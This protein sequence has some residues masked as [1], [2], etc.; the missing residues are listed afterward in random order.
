MQFVNKHLYIWLSAIHSHNNISLPS[1]C[2]WCTC[3][4]HVVWVILYDWCTFV[5]LPNW[6]CPYNCCCSSVIWTLSSQSHLKNVSY[7]DQLNQSD[8]CDRVFEERSLRKKQYYDTW[9]QNSRVPSAM[10][11]LFYAESVRIRFKDI[12]NGLSRPK[13]EWLS[14]SLLNEKTGFWFDTFW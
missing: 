7:S 11:I 12:G 3:N 1:I 14:L 5:L 9:I 10:T 8:R 13:T 2:Y 6:Y 4:L